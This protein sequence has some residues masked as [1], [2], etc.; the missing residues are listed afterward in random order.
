MMKI[1]KI[2]INIRKVAAIKYFRLRIF[3]KLNSNTQPKVFKKDK[4]WETLLN[5]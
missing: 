3:A 4:W 2:M 5:V 1:G